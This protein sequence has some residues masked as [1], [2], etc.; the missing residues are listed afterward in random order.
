MQ[1][2]RATW[3]LVIMPWLDLLLIV[4]MVI[5]VRFVLGAHA[6]VSPFTPFP[7]SLRIHEAM[8]GVV[9]L[10]AVLAFP[11]WIVAL[12]F[13]RFRLSVFAHLMQF[14]VY[15]I[16]CAAVNFSPLYE[17]TGLANRLFYW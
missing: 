16:G 3:L 7:P 4:A 17:P 12:C 6:T 9:F 1:A 14:T 8:V 11:A 13:K 5:H 15:I 2:K 10:L